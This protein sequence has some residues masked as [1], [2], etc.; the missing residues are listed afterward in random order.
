MKYAPLAFAPLDD[1]YLY[2]DD[3]QN[4]QPFHEESIWGFA[5]DY[6]Y[7]VED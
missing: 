5:P 6:E 2:E 7:N 4:E 1:D 3:E